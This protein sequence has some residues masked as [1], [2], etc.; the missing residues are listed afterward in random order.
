VFFQVELELECAE[1]I[2]PRPNVSDEDSDQWDHKVSDLQ[3]RERVEHAVGHGV[4]AMVPPGQSPV[5]RVKTTWLPEHEVRRITAHQEPS[6]TVVMEELAKLESAEDVRAKL[7]RL[8]AA[9]EEWIARQ[10]ATDAGDG[11]R[12]QT[13]DELV[14]KARDAR[15]RIAE[16]I[17]LLAGDVQVRQAFCLTNQAMAGR[18]AAPTSMRDVEATAHLWLVGRR[19]GR[20]S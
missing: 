9:Y 19:L 18:F 2:V 12:A 10:A 4:A 1:G 20:Q 8:P 3:F 13:R 6:V 14:H 17:E 15:R 11:K 7:Q 5:T 16:G